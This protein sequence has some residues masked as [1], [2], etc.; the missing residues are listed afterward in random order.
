M[1]AQTGLFERFVADSE[2]MVKAT[3]F[4]DPATEYKFRRAEYE[5]KRSQARE[6]MQA[7]FI[8]QI[9]LRKNPFFE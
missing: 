4:I 8:A 1:A 7:C 2:R 6:S 5:G 9:L 3:E